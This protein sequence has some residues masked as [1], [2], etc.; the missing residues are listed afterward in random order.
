MVFTL[1]TLAWKMYTLLMKS[2]AVFLG[3]AH[4]YRAVLDDSFVLYNSAS[5][6]LESAS[7]LKIQAIQGWRINTGVLYRPSF[8]LSLVCSWHACNLPGQG[9]RVNYWWIAREIRRQG[10][11]HEISWLIITDDLLII[12]TAVSCMMPP[13]CLYI[14]VCVGYIYM[15]F[16]LL[17]HH[18]PGNVLSFFFVFFDTTLVDIWFLISAGSVGKRYGILIYEFIASHEADKTRCWKDITKCCWR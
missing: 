8:C 9:W 1:W 7:T 12:E 11:T 13:E 10:K 16:N 5:S 17:P 14:H 3:V 2:R 6:T 15:S 4:W 18:H